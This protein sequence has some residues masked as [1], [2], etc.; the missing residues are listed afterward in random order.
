MSNST[1]PSGGETQPVLGRQDRRKRQNPE[2]PVS[3]FM[4]IFLSPEHGCQD[5]PGTRLSP[6]RV[7]PSRRAAEPASV[8]Q[9][10]GR[11]GAGHL[12]A[13]PRRGVCVHDVGLFSGSA[14][15]RTQSR[16]PPG[17]AAVSLA[18]TVITASLALPTEAQ[19]QMDAA[20]CTVPPLASGWGRGYRCSS[21]GGRVRPGSKV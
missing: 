12:L 17:T 11:Q 19:R 1:F 4:F 2:G 21:W 8:P 5:L 20:L 16:S 14:R 13:L 3:L 7:V 10:G 15:M 18:H 6:S 9:A